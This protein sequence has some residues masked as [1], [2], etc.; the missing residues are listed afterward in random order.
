[1]SPFSHQAVKRSGHLNSCP[2]V[3]LKPAGPHSALKTRGREE[4][5]A[6]SS[7]MPYRLTENNKRFI[8]LLASLWMKNG[9]L[10]DTIV[11]AHVFPGLL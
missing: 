9:G 2:F 11:S 7:D 10:P 5:E 3:L 1:M 8:V 6:P 4:F